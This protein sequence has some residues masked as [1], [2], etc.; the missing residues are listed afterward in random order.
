MDV[1]TDMSCQRFKCNQ[2]IWC[3]RDDHHEDDTHEEDFLSR[4]WLP[5]GNCPG[6]NHPDKFEDL[7][8]RREMWGKEM[9]TFIV[10]DKE[11]FS[12]FNKFT[13][14]K[15][16]RHETD[17]VRTFRP[18]NVVHMIYDEEE[19]EYDIYEG[20]AHCWAKVDD[21]KLPVHFIRLKWV[22]NNPNVVQEV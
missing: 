14:H 17:I 16:T 13:F 9:N 11:I 4:H 15:K 20:E 3:N 10:E 12:T 6:F 21:K 1:Q 22:N 2:G 5:P 19:N 18:V 7:M 8:E